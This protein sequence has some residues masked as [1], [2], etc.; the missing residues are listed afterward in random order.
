MLAL[1]V[2]ILALTV[3]AAP[4][5]DRLIGRNAGWILA[6]P[7]VVSAVLAARTYQTTGAGGGGPHT[8]TYEWMPTL[9]VE[10]AFRFDGLSLVFL[11]LVLLIGAGVL[12]YSTRYLSPGRNTG[13]WFFITGFAA[14]MALLVL[15]DDLIV[16]YV[17]WELTTLCSFF[18]IA[19][20]GGFGGRA[21]AIRTLL[22]TVF[23]GLLLLSA[24]VIMIVTTGTTSLSEVIASD[25]WA[26]Q[27]HL[28]ITVAILVALAAF[29]KSAQFPF[30]AWL[31]DSMAAISPV[32]AYLHAAAMVKAGIYLM[33]RYSP[34]FDDVMWWQMMLVG[35]GAVTA[36]F[37]AM[38][39]VKRDDLKEVLA[40]S[41][42]SQLGLITFTIGLGY[43]GALT[44]AIVHTVAHACFKAALFMLI[45]IVDHEAGTRRFSTLRGKR[46]KMPVTKTLTVI[47]AASMAGIPPL[48]GFVS[49]EKIVDAT[50][51]TPVPD[52]DF[53]VI[54]TG[55]VVVT[56]IMTFVY[57]ARIILGVFGL[58]KGENPPPGA[59]AET[60]AEA[61][62]TF[63]AVPALL[64]AVTVV[65]GLAPQILERPVA[66]A[67]LAAHG[68][69]HE[70]GLALWHGF[71]LAL[72]MSAFII[73][74]GALCLWRIDIV[75]GLLSR[76]MSP[77]SGL[78]VV[79][80]L[81]SG[82]I[83]AGGYITRLS[84]TTSMR[85]HL[86]APMVILVVIAF[87]GTLGITELPPIVGDPSR[88][89]DWVMTGLVALGVVAA[90]RANS[91]LTVIIVI[92]I[93]GFSM[94][95]W[96][97]GLGAADVATTQLTVEVLTVVVLV[98]VLHRLPQR[99]KPE[100]RSSEST[101]IVIA[102][103][104]A[105]ATFIG[106]VALT[107]RREKSEAA[108]YYLRRAEEETGGSN[109]VNT[110]LVDFRAL[111]TFGELTVLGVAGL[112]V[113]VLV[114]SRPLARPKDAELDTQSPVA[115]PRENA[116]FLQTA[117]LVIGPIILAMSAL[118]F[119]RGHYETGGG[120]V[121]ALVAGAGLA[122]LYL[123]APSDE[124]GRL[125]LSYN[126]L[127][128]LAI[129]I[130]AVTGMFGFLEGSF[131]APFDIN[132]GFTTITS[133]LVFDLG[134][135]LGVIGLVAAAVNLLGTADAR[136]LSPD[137]HLGH[138]H[139]PTLG[140]TREHLHGSGNFDGDA[141][142][143]AD[144]DGPVLDEHGEYVFDTVPE[145][146]TDDAAATDR[147]ERT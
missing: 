129:V 64:G 141:G 37:G 109:I 7:L 128:G 99:F 106:I 61:P 125:S 147:A 33:L 119:L 2:A 127:I 114:A 3:V 36:V 41:T 52:A 116:V 48:A 105:V 25:A 69:P 142:S 88:T 66:D 47:T 56:S 45:G 43:E 77:I 46:L 44:A 75:Q 120:F 12:L 90:I 11:M 101:S 80:S 31:P 73:A 76:S 92:S 72:A 54:L 39:A 144:D 40:Y 10:L 139:R 85:R 94:T 89:S 126:L 78:G 42:M 51:S 68:A 107:G 130:G 91:S 57:S 138:P 117:M 81:R 55:T 84:G 104:M 135:Y 100:Q 65:L 29:T 8:E 13:F 53:T 111:D 83:H 6:A 23:G 28:L 112:T 79:E 5:A 118:L 20:T 67:V 38:T 108:E 102:G 60:V 15:T 87:V 21:P 115:P 123:S 34:M 50:L 132:L 74:A 17:A 19:M 95:L 113:A 137:S 103:A 27:R 146:S 145:D 58:R 59:D 82:I 124:E 22:V 143:D 35:A 140:K 93:V 1:I 122:L 97:Y 18:L 26:G 86:A 14:A 16:F 98:L 131:L 32:S 133:T 70:P 49:K 62:A 30:Q 96:F 4:F 24:T 136:G 9:G 63:W 110:I 71:N 134:V 121:A